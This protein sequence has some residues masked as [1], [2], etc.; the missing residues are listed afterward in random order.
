MRILEVC[1]YDLARPGGVQQQVLLLASGF[2]RLGH[3]VVVAAPGGEVDLGKTVLVDANGSKAPVC[4]TPD[5]SALRGASADVDVVHLHEP[6]VPMIGWRALGLAPP[7]VGTFHRDG[8]SLAYRALG[9]A[10]RQRLRRLAGASAV[11]P[12]AARTI[13]RVAGCETRIVPNGIDLGEFAV[14]AS[15]ARDRVVFVGR[16][17]PRKGLVVLLEAI[18]MVTRPCEVVI[19]GVGPETERLRAFVKDPRVRFVG[20][21]AREDLVR[22]LVGAEIAVVPSLAGESFGLVVLEGLAAGCAVAA[23]DLPAHR[24]VLGQPPAGALFPPGDP[25]QLARVIEELLGH[26]LERRRLQSMAGERAREFSLDRVVG[27]YLELFAVSG[28]TE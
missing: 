5:L 28:I 15:K 26:S 12:L 2:R 14:V 6:L 17:E 21:L 25:V 7:I 20:A 16:H 8:A 3:D 24:F 19:A 22:L 27:S 23:S 11:S 18:G 13:S 9:R 1:P 4:L 10:M